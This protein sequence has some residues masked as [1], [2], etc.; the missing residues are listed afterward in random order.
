MSNVFT[1]GMHLH[2][3]VHILCKLGMYVYMSLF[4]S[5]CVCMYSL[6]RYVQCFYIYVYVYTYWLMVQMCRCVCG[7]TILGVYPPKMMTSFFPI[8]D[9]TGQGLHSVPKRGCLFNEGLQ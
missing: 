9:L 1:Y 8:K 7:T 4:M 3:Y 2:S 5:V 6:Y